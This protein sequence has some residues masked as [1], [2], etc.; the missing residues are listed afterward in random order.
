MFWIK[1]FG[2]DKPPTD[3]D[4]TEGKDAKD[5][6]LNLKIDTTNEE[7]NLQNKYSSYSEKAFFDLYSNCMEELESKEKIEREIFKKISFIKY[8]D[9]NYKLALDK[10]I[11][12]SI[13]ERESIPVLFVSGYYQGMNLYKLASSS[14]MFFNTISSTR[15]DWQRLAGRSFS[16]IVF[17]EFGDKGS[18]LTCEEFNELLTRTGRGNKDFKIIFYLPKEDKDIPDFVQK[19]RKQK[20]Y[21]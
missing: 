9:D 3:K 19:L 13:G 11:K 16:H 18:R 4:I 21:T 7:N 17:H 15:L 2:L 1:V 12:L 8:S 14:V 6:F 5:V 10:A 20:K